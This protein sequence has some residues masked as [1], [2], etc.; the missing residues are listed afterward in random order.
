MLNDTISH[1][2]I[3]EKLG[4]GGMGVV[5]KAEDTRLH[6]FVALKFLPDDVARDPQALARFQR[7]AQA[8][9]ALNHPNICTIYDIGEQDGKAF[10]AMEFLEGMTLKH[11][12]SGKPIETESVLNLSIEIADAL[13][14]A[15]AKG[16]VHRDIKP[17]NIFVTDRG[18]AKVLDFG[19]AKVASAVGSASHIASGETMT[20]VEEEHL[21]SPGSTLGTVAYMSPE[22]VRGKDLDSRTDLFSFGV[23]LYEMTT[24]VLPFQGETSAVIFEAVMN[25]TPLSPIRLNP[26]LPA[27]LEEIIL[28]VLEKDRGLRYQHASDMKADLQRLKRDSESGRQSHLSAEFPAAI[29]PPPGQRA[30]IPSKVPPGTKLKWCAAALV[31]VTILALGFYRSFSRPSP[32]PFQSV[33]ITKITENGNTPQAALSPDGKYILHVVVDRGQETLWLR[34][35][36]TGSNTQVVSAVAKAH[37]SGLSFSPDG[38]YLYFQ[39]S[40]QGDNTYRYL[41]RAPILGGTSERVV[42]DIDSPITFS[43]DGRKIAYIVWNDPN[44]GK[45]RLN[46]RS[47]DSGEERVLVDLPLAS[48]LRSLSWSPDGKVI[49]CVAAQ[50]LA[51]MGSL[52]AVDVNSGKLTAFLDA[53]DRT[54][55]EA[56]WLPSGKG[57][58]LLTSDRDSGFRRN[59]IAWVSYP[60][61]VLTPISRD[62]ND[63]ASLSVSADGRSVVAVLNE[64]HSALYVLPQTGNPGA[65]AAHAA[66]I[67]SDHP[68]LDFAW[69]AGKQLVV[70]DSS[71]LSRV[72]HQGVKVGLNTNGTIS[73]HSPSECRDGQHL[74]FSAYGVAENKPSVWRRNSVDGNLK[75]ITEA[76]HDESPLCSPD[77]RFVFYVAG[78]FVG[79]KV[80]KVSSEG[81]APV[82]LTDLLAVSN[83]DLSP[84]GGKIVFL[85]LG[86]TEDS[87]SKAAIISAA[88]GQTLQLM[89]FEKPSRNW[90]RFS[91][92]GKAIVYAARE[93]GVDN[94]WSQPLDGSPGRK[95]TSFDSEHMEDFHWSFDGSELGVI[96]SHT[97]S[98]VVLLRDKNP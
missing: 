36:P 27:K 69:T 80:M 90:F 91:P 20:A 76:G 95:L 1:Y 61:G 26:G 96:R 14:A 84:D 81:G 23:V 38:S 55:G 52:I 73:P 45:F 67:A 72:D 10:I 87:Q 32:V 75:R 86:G 9:S 31:A 65:D 64:L 59:Q 18:H 13:D 22:Q 63:Y 74:F 7:E 79:G 83:L 34:N 98:D 94:L 70:G 92:D 29:S 24:G 46:I 93:S 19:L 48:A 25:R 30:S 47:L 56:V 17:A 16:I 15:H 50:P 51:H 5:Y 62:T 60:E 57:L 97:N 6:R 21:T 54:F 37:F 49:L 77:G 8:A 35:I 40:E 41:Y 66:L 68:I 4:G 43:P 89:K 78:T 11:R 3:L 44:A 71:N 33:S 42:A 39:R 12:I 58:V 82:G 53:D 85:A 28:K 2:R 88:S